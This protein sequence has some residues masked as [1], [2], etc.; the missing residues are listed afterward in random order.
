M[1][2]S[3][4]V[5][6]VEDNPDDAKMILH[7]LNRSGFETT[8]RRVDTEAAFL[9]SLNGGLDLILCDHTMPEFSGLRALELLKTRSLE[10]PFI[11]VSGT[12]GEEMAVEAMKR[13]ATD[14]LLK[15]RLAR[16]GPSVHQ[17]LEQFRLRKKHQHLEHELIEAQK[18]QVIG[19]LAGGVAHDFN[20]ILSVIM[21][22]C[23]LT[24]EQTR[25]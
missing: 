3:L 18:T 4:K 10:I 14:Y 23:D 13:G 24:M 7:E 2:Q 11:I 15:D 8:S 25:G 17:A 16:L 22:Y 19:Q 20:N 21:G 12:I 6:L 5:L 1:A 9:A